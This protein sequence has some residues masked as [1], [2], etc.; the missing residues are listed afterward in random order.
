MALESKLIL[1]FTRDRE[2]ARELGMSAGSLRVALF[3]MRQKYR[4]SLKAEIAETLSDEADL[5]EEIKHL[6]GLFE[7]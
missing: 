1:S 2:L 6:V 4:A 3:R 5:E 7:R